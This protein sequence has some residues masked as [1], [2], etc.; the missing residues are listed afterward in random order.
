MSER[1]KES[2][3]PALPPIGFVGLGLL[4]SALADRLSGAGFNLRGYDKGQPKTGNVILLDSVTAVFEACSIIVLSLPESGDVAEIL[5][6]AGASIKPGRHTIVDTTT[7]DPDQMRSFFEALRE[8][9]VEYI[10]ANIAG[11]SEAAR[12]GD[13]PLF[14]G[15]EPAAIEALQ[16]VFDAM[17][18]KSF[19]L[20]PAGSAS[21]FKLAH[22]LL[23]GLNRAVL[24][25]TL[26]FCEALGFDKRASLEVLKQTPAYT[27]V[28]ETKGERMVRSDFD[29]PQARLS[30]HLKDVRL[31]LEYAERYGARTPLSATHCGLLEEVEDAG[32]GQCDNSAILTA[33]INRADRSEGDST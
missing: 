18:K 29:R 13:T 5:K 17:S 33:F 6:E 10:E 27:Y 14:L 7:G 3:D 16:P 1:R 28:M 12:R 25:E 2:K 22:N 11:S 32:L 24:A 4:G 15:G 20:G 26:S 8:R 19:K 23:L 21:K 31:I 9:G 30:Q